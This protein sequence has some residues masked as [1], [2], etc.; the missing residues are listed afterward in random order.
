MGKPRARKPAPTPPAGLGGIVNRE[1]SAR[2]LRW[3]YG[4]GLILTAV[5]WMGWFSVEIYDSDF[6]WH[7]KTGQYIVEHY[8]LPIPDPFAFTTARAPL[9]YAGEDVTRNFNLTHEW[10]SQALQYLVYRAGGF[11]GIV[12]FRAAMLAGLSAFIGA[13]A[14]QRRRSFYW[15]VAAAFATAIMA[16]PYALDRPYL[17]T[18]LLVAATIAILEYRRWLWL[19]PCLFLVWANSHGGFI[20]GWIA[21]GAYCAEAGWLTWR[22]GRPPAATYLW[23]VSAV[24]LAASIL[25]PN[26][27]RVLQVLLA[28]RQSYLQSGLE[29][30]SKP[31]WWRPSEFSFLLFGAA[32]VLLWRWRKVRPVDW[33]LFAAFAAVALSGQRNIL[34]IGLVA[35]IL[36]VTYFPWKPTVP[37]WIPLTA[38][39]AGVLVA[40]G[41]ST[42]S[43]FQ[44]RAAE[45]KLPSGGADFLLS[46]RLPGPIFNTYEFGGYLI[47]RL[48]PEQRVFIDGRALSES[49]FKD[50]LRILYNHDESGGPSAE[51]LLDRYDIQTIVMNTIECN[52]GLIYKLAPSLADPRQT[53]W[54]LVYS[55]ATAIVLTRHPPPG[56]EALNPAAIAEHME[57]ECNWN[58]EHEPQTAR[59]AR[60]LGQTFT[61]VGDFTR[62]RGWLAKYLLSPHAPDPVA[63]DAYRRLVASGY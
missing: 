45:W 22:G 55:D 34:F 1:S 37:G 25:N 48:W 15:A 54:K 2:R 62:A 21:L 27:L 29:E 59:C 40:L 12:L 60:A 41:W 53:E 17:V 52:E 58:M 6:W 61:Q 30:W 38:W 32:L 7:L 24:S 3:L 11:G 4:V 50:Y 10:L 13:I 26:G 36:I 43:A 14:W 39:I 9:A 35:P 5:L 44:L 57:A 51:Q 16:R 20:L 33:M 19:L 31:V 46:R 23:L 47:W 18:F 8:R 63:E 28:Y 49:V 56:V 42:S